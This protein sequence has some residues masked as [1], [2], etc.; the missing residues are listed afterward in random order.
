MNWKISLGV[1]G[2]I[3][4]IIFLIRCADEDVK[5]HTTVLGQNG[6]RYE[7]YREAC[8]DYDF[9]AAHDFITLME[10]EKDGSFTK[11]WDD[12]DVD[13]AI[14]YVFQREASYLL[15]EI[16][17]DGERR[18][19]YLINES[20]QNQQISNGSYVVDLAIMDENTDFAMKVLG[21]MSI[22]VKKFQKPEGTYADSEDYDII[23]NY[24]KTCE[25]IL[26]Y[27]ISNGDADLAKKSL[28][29]FIQDAFIDDEYNIQYKNDSKDTARLKYDE[30]VKS[31]VFN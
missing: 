28:S 19:I 15:L 12:Y 30:A 11:E 2:C 18:V 21:V 26:D 31:G 7:S 17:E 9:Q 5:K 24:N 4:M 20:P 22:A 16:G 1:L 23:F 27:A 29:M 8:D 6:T 13:E 25:K 3:I 14:K 10:K